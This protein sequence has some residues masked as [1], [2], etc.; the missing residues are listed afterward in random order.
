MEW[1]SWRVLDE[2][3]L[4]ELLEGAQVCRLAMAEGEQPYLVPVAVRAVR[5]ESG[6]VFRIQSPVYGA[7]MEYLRAN[8]RVALELERSCAEGTDTVVAFGIARFVLPPGGGGRAEIKV[9]AYHL[10]GR[11]FFAQKSPPGP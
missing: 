7:K 3:E 9:T 1:Q 5:E 2:E 11:R 10:T 4:A 6:W 8:R